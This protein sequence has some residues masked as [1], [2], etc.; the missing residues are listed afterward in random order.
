MCCMRYVFSLHNEAW[1]KQIVSYI[2]YLVT[3][4]EIVPSKTMLKSVMIKK[5]GLTATKPQNLPNTIQEISYKY[6]GGVLLQVMD[7]ILIYLQ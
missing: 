3:F 1:L 2:I 6:F 7:K 5:K 4:W